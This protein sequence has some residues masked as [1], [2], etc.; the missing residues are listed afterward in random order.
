F[1]HRL[2][3]HS[4]VH[5]GHVESYIEPFKTFPNDCRNIVAQAEKAL[6]H[7]FSPL[8]GE[9]YE[10]PHAI[11]WFGDFQGRSWLY[12][13]VDDLQERLQRPLDEQVAALQ[14]MGPVERT[15]NFN[16]LGQFVD[17]G[18]AYWIT[19]NEPFASEFVVQ[20]V[21]WGERNQPMYGI[22]W[23]YPRMVATRALNW[24]L[25][26]LMFLGSE[27]LQGENLSRILRTLLYHG[28]YL[29]ALLSKGCKDQLA[30]AASL[31]LLAAHFPE[32]TASRRWL[33]LAQQSLEEGAG[34]EFAK[35]GLHRS[36]SLAMHR[37]ATEWLLLVAAFDI[38]NSRAWEPLLR[39][40]EAA[41]EALAY[42]RSP[43][44]LGCEVGAHLCEGLLGRQAG[45]IEHTR[46]ILAMAAVLLERGDF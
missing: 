43:A 21:D 29:A 2:R 38:T 10:F 35:D 42:L 4:F 28:G 14:Q 40:L 9:P 7:K 33:V 31:Y 18:R 12:A 13:H 26:F 39:P 25:S 16:Q 46:R 20:A 24:T 5:A 30:V 17:L 32:F 45:P 34:R 27:Q 44:L 11:D 23:L 22:N 19:D 8:G 6:Q 37:E 15:W 36:A 3:P 41:V 1:H